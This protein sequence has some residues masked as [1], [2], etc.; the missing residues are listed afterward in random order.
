MHLL[1]AWILHLEM[2]AVVGVVV[3]CLY[4]ACHG[5]SAFL[6]I[7][8]RWVVIAL[9]VLMLA[10]SAVYSVAVFVGPHPLFVGRPA[11]LT[12]GKGLFGLISLAVGVLSFS[13]WPT[14]RWYTVIRR[15]TVS[16]AAT[17]SQRV[18][19]FLRR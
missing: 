3:F 18:L 8:L 14:R 12:I 13:Q 1:A 11:P 17:V 9:G 6:G 19:V 2:I 7:S 15:R 16:F 10:L 5:L 4:L